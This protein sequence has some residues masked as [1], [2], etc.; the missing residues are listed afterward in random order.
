MKS[1]RW[2]NR[3]MFECPGC[4]CRHLIPIEEGPTKGPVWDWNGSFESPTLHPSLLT[5][6][7]GDNPRC[8]SYVKDGTIQFLKDSTHELAGKT[9]EL[10]DL[11]G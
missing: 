1:K 7:A 11:D 6:A 10:P 3:I 8:H 2:M 9:V 5:H 4:K